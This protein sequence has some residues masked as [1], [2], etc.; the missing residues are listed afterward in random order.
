ASLD[1][2]DCLFHEG[3]A[4]DG[5]DL[6]HST[7]VMDI[8][9]FRVVEKIRLLAFVQYRRNS[10]A[11]RWRRHRLEGRRSDRIQPCASV[12][13]LGIPLKSVKPFPPRSSLYYLA[14]APRPTPRIPRSQPLTP[15]LPS[16]WTCPGPRS[17]LAISRAAALPHP[18]RGIISAG[19]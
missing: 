10:R 15:G 12:K 1:G 3:L 11:D 13:G 6:S 17:M 4:G 2:V 9:V 18:M 8:L 5:P 7:S 16:P 19:A 14:H